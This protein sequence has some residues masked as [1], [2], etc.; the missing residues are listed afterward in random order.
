M[1]TNQVNRRDFLQKTAFIA[2]SVA[3]SPNVLLAATRRKKDNL[4]I[5]L[6]G[7]GYYS[8][9]VL[10]KSFGFT[11]N[12]HLEGIVTGTP[13]KAE[14][15][16][17]KYNLADKNIYSYQSFDQIANNPDI[18]VIY[19]VLPP[20]MH[21]EYVE[22]AA[23]AGKQVWCEKP[24]APSVA[25]CEAMIAACKKN[26][27]NLAIGYRCQHDSNVQEY[28][29]LGQKRVFGKV[30]T[31]ESSAAYTE[32]RTDHWKQKKAMGG[33][34]MGDMGVYAIQGARLITGEEPLTV[35]AKLYTNRPQI[36][37]EVEEIAD[38]TL[39]FPSGAV[40][41]CHSSYGDN[42]NFLRAEC[43]KGWIKVEPQSGYSGIKGE[44]PNGKWS[45]PLPNQQAKQMDEDALA[46]MTSK[47]LIAPGEE[48]LRD[49][50]IVEA[51]YRSGKSGKTEKI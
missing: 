14:T 44:S 50:R 47:K 42:A 45:F 38:Y 22:R 32:G 46:I 1:E 7:L 23:K 33:G 6:V 20:S 40:A 49:I 34:V 25:E 21:R 17:Q 13:A 11:K 24:M 30:K 51:V 15:W 9:D 19:V 41:K 39:E 36:Y 18:D 35:S 31:I 16:K 48:G 27:V 2:A 43:E 26:N 12:C 3:F 29:R 5:A 28:M 37:T 10:A 8:T 4:G